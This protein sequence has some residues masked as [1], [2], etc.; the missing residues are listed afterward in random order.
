MLV[1]PC[2]FLGLMAGMRDLA[3]MEAAAYMACEDKDF[4]GF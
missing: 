4:L 1:F 3:K 2:Y